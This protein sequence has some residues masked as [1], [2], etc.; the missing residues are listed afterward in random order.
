MEIVVALAGLC[1]GSYVGALSYRRPKGLSTLKGRSICPHCERKIAWYDNIPLFS[2]FILKGRCRNCGKKISPRYPLI[3]LG[4][5]LLFLGFYYSLSLCSGFLAGSNLCLWKADFGIT[6]YIFFTALILILSTIFVIDLENKIIPDELI[7]WGILVIS[8]FYLFFKPSIIFN[9]FLIGFI[10]SASFL[11]IHLLTKGRGMGL[12]DV[13][14]VILGGLLLGWPQTLIWLF[15]SFFSGA[16]IGVTLLL[17]K[18]ARLGREIPFGPYL[19]GSLIATIIFGE[20]I[21]SLYI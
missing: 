21:L 1:L 7:F 15:L 16:I 3:E 14:F 5:L 18:K 2:F 20:K 9:N 17:L 10:A 13:K 6:S 12:G 8:F 4:V 11:L 19:V